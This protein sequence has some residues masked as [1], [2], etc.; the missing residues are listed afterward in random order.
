[1]NVLPTVY[2][3]GELCELIEEIGFLPYFSN[4]M[5]GF[6]VMDITRGMKWWS[7]IPELDPWDWRV[8]ISGEHKI[9]YGKL[10]KGN[11]G[12]VSLKWYPVFANFRRNGYDF[13]SRYEEGLASYKSKQIML[14]FESTG[15]E[16]AS[17]ALKRAAGFGKEGLKGFEGAITAL[18]MQ[19]YLTVSG[20][21]QRLNKRGEPYGWNVGYFSTP[22]DVFGEAVVTSCY[23]EA[24]EVSREK[25]VDRLAEYVHTA[26]DAE[27]RKFI[28]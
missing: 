19:T 5:R 26:F 28:S 13:Q 27:I 4:E 20:F 3:K 18:Q 10:F 1:M 15:T 7:D 23:G 16:L 25:I 9:A 17:N 22:E 24:P 12:F 11:A 2:S 6:S 14:H 8:Q 21:R